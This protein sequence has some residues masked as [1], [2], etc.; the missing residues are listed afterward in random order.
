MLDTF[1]VPSA[2]ASPVGLYRSRV[3]DPEQRRHITVGRDA[4]LADTLDILKEGLGKRPKHHLLFIG[5]RGIGK[6]HLLAL[7]KDE[8]GRDA[9]LSAGYH[10]VRFPEEPHRLLSFA[11]VLLGICEILRDTLPEEREWHDLHER[12]CTE[13]QAE[14]IVD[15]LVPAI[16]QRWRSRRQALVVMLENLHEVFG[17]QIKDPLSIAAVRGFLMQDNGCL[18]VATAPLHFGAITDHKEP[19]YDFF[20]VQILDQLTDEQTIELVRRNL[21]WEG[22]ADLLAEF[23]N[24]RPR[25]LALYR[26]TGGN[27]RLTLMLYELIAHE[28]VSEVKRQFEMLLDRITPFYQDRMRD[29]GPQERAV[30]ETMAVMRDEPKTP[31][32]IAARMRMKSA[33]L[34]SLLN[35]LQKAHYLRAVEN[36]ADKRSRFYTIRE[37]FFDIW[38]AMN[39]SRGARRRLPFLVD[40]FAQFYPS[41]ELRNRKREEYRRRLASGEFDVPEGTGRAEDSREGLDFLSE[42][43][44]EAERAAEKLRLAAIHAGAG[45][46]SRAG[47]YLHEAR[48]LPLD[49]VGTWI[50]RHSE[51]AP[52]DNYLSEIEDLIAC[53]ESHRAGDLERFAEKLKALGAGL[54]YKSWSE[55]KLDFLRE[56]LALLPAGRDRVETRLQIG[57]HLHDLARW[58]EAE[59][60]LRA[61]M[62]EAASLDDTELQASTVNNLASLLHDTNRLAE[63]EQFMRRSLAIAGQSFGPEHPTVAIV[64]N[65]LA[66]LLHGTNRLAEAEPLM[67]R[68]LAID[69]QSFGPEHPKVA[70]GLNNLA[71]LLH[72]T[73]RLAEAEQLM[74]RAL[75]IDEQSFGPE[76]Q[77][78]AIDL[79]NLALLLKGTNRPTEAEPLMRRTL[80]IDEQSFGP[81]HPYIA[82]DLNNLAFLLGA[83]NRL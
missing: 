52:A 60:Q 19:F 22:R 71:S 64:L 58:A 41:I 15:T 6:T 23:D 32:A 24:L 2:T 50:V 25:L 81:E 73:N 55:T 29:L 51:Q 45:D 61:A 56:H 11:D 34:S 39:V 49:P 13:Q 54:S 8:I 9:G 35:R 66:Q 30:L 80:A 78:V 62:D 75:A 5:P 67:R 20:D 48:L 72:D 42:V 14:V 47:D 44:T 65:N 59:E 46:A 57:N 7:I 3:T 70:I 69:E 21:Q 1:T 43:G 76:D 63:A 83:T 27:P 28:A 79:A 18:L 31:T 36:P 68:A 53:W 16:R 17:S 26:M 82:R 40:F 38:L 74:R 77:T 33:Q 10:V 4:I 37:G 12:L